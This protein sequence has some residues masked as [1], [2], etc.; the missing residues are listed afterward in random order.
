MD[1]R[2]PE[3]NHYNLNYM[4]DRKDNRDFSFSK[5]LSRKKLRKRLRKAPKVLDHSGKMSPVKNQGRLGSCVGFA[6]SAM[7]EWQEQVEHLKEVERGKKNHRDDKYYDLSEAW[8]YWMCKKI[9][10]WPNSEGTSIRCAMKV[11]AKIGVPCEN[12]WPYDDKVYGEPKKWAKLVA[13]WSLIHSYWRVKNLKELRVAL[14]KGPV[15]IG[16]GC[17]EEIFDVG[18][19]GVVRNPANPNYC[20]GG[21]A[22]CVVGY[23][24]KKKRFKFK[25]SWGKS[26]GQNG[27]GYLSYNYIRKYM[28]DA[29]ACKDLSVTKKMIKKARKLIK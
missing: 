11:L 3:V 18:K 1:I 2:D 21:H 5:S 16:I 22:I 20:Y 9:D 26:W 8:I 15:V 19:D 27:Y 12:A 17:Y 10:P 29:W 25:N 4:K 23:D 28:W 7:K 13:L 14:V 6:V 24:N